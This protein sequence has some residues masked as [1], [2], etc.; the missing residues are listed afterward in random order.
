MWST[1]LDL[2][3]HCKNRRSEAHTNKQAVFSGARLYEISKKVGKRTK[4][5]ILFLKVRFRLKLKE[6]K[7]NTDD[8]DAHLKLEKEKVYL[9]VKISKLHE[10]E[11]I[12]ME[13][14]VANSSK[15]D[16]TEFQKENLEEN[17]EEVVAQDFFWKK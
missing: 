5:R 3:V 9:E 16:E 10:G 1:L 12:G 15:R 4:I 14:M 13:L 6:K 8:S 2:K 11:A 17:R 7:H